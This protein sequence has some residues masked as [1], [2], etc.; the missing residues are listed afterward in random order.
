[1][2]CSDNFEISSYVPNDSFAEVI[3]VNEN[4]PP[5]VQALKGREQ[6]ITVSF[7]ELEVRL[8]HNNQQIKF[9]CLKDYLYGEKPEINKDTL[10][11]LYISA[12]T[13]F[14][15]SRKSDITNPE[16][17]ESETS[18]ALAKFLRSDPYLNAAQLRFGYALTLNRAQGQQFSTV[19]ANM[20]NDQGKTNEQYFR[21]IYTLFSLVQNKL[22]LSNIFS[23]T[24]FYRASWNARNAQIDSVHPGNQIVFDP[25][26]E[27]GFADIAEF[28]IP[29]K[30]LRNLYLHL[31]NKLETQAINIKTYNH[32]NYQ[33]NYSFEKKD[34]TASCS[35]RL[36]YNGRFQITRIETI[37]SHPPEFAEQVRNIISSDLRIEN[38]FQEEVYSLT[39]NKLD[40]YQIRIKQIEHHSYQEIYYLNSEK[41][42]VKLQLSYD[43]DGF[44]TTVAPV[45]YT[46]PGILEAVRLALEI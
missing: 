11:A 46:T 10:L 20:D 14:L 16:E 30:A 43:G 34:S 13:R 17:S 32:H 38:K 8:L 31:K 19:I 41:G 2:K 24:P 29:E 7:I 35:I 6:P 18:L 26:S 5:L 15:Q 45:K 21:W 42:D 27:M 28:N 23:I 33:E 40:K 25:N 4:I 44:I 36:Y 39:R 12:K 1:M 22:I 3:Q 9:L 37:N